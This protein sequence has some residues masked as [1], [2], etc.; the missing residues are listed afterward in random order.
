MPEC[1]HFSSIGFYP[2]ERRSRIP[3]IQGVQGRSRSILLRVLGNAGDEAS[4]AFPAGK[5]HD[6]FFFVL[7]VTK[8]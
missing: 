8:S 6:N 2:L 4:W 7:E 1:E 3:Q 5:K